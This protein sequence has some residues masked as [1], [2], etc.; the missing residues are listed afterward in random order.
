MDFLAVFLFIVCVV[1]IT[2]L[3]AVLGVFTI[4]ATVG[5]QKTENMTNTREKISESG[6]RNINLENEG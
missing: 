1:L 3:A 5:E 2:T 4:G 6:D